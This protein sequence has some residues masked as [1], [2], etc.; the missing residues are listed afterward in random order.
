M[1]NSISPELG[2]MEGGTTVTINGTGFDQNSTCGII[3]RLGI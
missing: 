2:P 1:I 3:V